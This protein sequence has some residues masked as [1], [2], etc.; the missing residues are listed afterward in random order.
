MPFWT[1]TVATFSMLEG[2]FSRSSNEPWEINNNTFQVNLHLEQS[3][4]HC[5]PTLL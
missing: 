1:H 5:T 3:L 2:H 4:S